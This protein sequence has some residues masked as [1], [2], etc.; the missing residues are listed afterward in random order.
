M[1]FRLWHRA[2]LASRSTSPVELWKTPLPRGYP[3]TPVEKTKEDTPAFLALNE[4]GIKPEDS[5]AFDPYSRIFNPVT[6]RKA[7]RIAEEVPKELVIPVVNVTAP[8]DDPEQGRA[9]LDSSPES[10]PGLQS[11]PAAQR[12]SLADN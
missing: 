12:S 6:V 11:V 4:R 10:P 5:I 1:I 7:E 2:A 9:R 3:I 8:I